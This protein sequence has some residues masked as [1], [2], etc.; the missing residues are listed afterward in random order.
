MTKAEPGE[1]ELTYA[2]FENSSSLGE[3]LRDNASK[4]IQIIQIL[5]AKDHIISAAKRLGGQNK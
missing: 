2:D 5:D 1:P 3:E 4:L